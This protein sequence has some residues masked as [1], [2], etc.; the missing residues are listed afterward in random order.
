MARSAIITRKSAKEKLSEFKNS[1][2]DIQERLSLKSDIA[3]KIED[4]KDSKTAAQ[5]LSRIYSIHKELSLMKNTN[6]DNLRLDDPTRLSGNGVFG[7][8]I[9]SQKLHSYTSDAGGPSGK[10]KSGPRA[11]PNLQLHPPQNPISQAPSDLRSPLHPRN[12]RRHKVPSQ[13]AQ[14]PNRRPRHPS[15]PRQDGPAPIN[16]GQRRKFRPIGNYL[17]SHKR[18]VQKIRR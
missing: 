1:F 7:N 8:Q 3:Q 6:L 12:H 4:S 2:K 11:G 16:L 13:H 5:D 18:E 10:K 17:K 15:L 9:L 14:L